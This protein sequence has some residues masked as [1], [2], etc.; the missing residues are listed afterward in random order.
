M[1]IA[2]AEMAAGAM[3]KPGVGG[4]RVSCAKV[5]ADS[6]EDAVFVFWFTDLS[7]AWTV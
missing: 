5:V 2:V 6:G 3:A 1:V 4:A 7:R